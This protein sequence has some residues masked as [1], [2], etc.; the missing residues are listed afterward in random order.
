MFWTDR[1]VVTSLSNP[2]LQ[3]LV[4]KFFAANLPGESKKKNLSSTY[5]GRSFFSRMTLTN[6][7]RR[8][9]LTRA[10]L[11]ERNESQGQPDVSTSQRCKVIR[12]NGIFDIT[13]RTGYAASQSIIITSEGWTTYGETRRGVRHTVGA[14][15]RMRRGR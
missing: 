12:T 8:N 3:D 14:T 7:C 10:L 6:V 4:D 9:Y 1:D 15:W 2:V 13:S 5:C 11:R